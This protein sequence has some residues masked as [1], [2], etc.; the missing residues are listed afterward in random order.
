MD[1]PSKLST[2]KT[3]FDQYIF[4]TQLNS[5]QILTQHFSSAS[6]N[7]FSPNACFASL[8]N[9]FISLDILTIE[10]YQKI[11]QWLN[12]KM[13]LL[14]FGIINWGYDSKSC[15]QC[16]NSVTVQNQRWHYCYE[17]KFKFNSNHFCRANQLILKKMRNQFFFHT[18]Q[19]SLI[20]CFYTW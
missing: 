9:F 2:Q 3:Q 18:F 11:V 13:Y 8:I 4:S 5:K 17:T 15:Q 16:W 10:M 6:V 19:W 7:R 20:A 1:L 12:T 14:L